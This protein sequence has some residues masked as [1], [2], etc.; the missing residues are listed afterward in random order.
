M[1]CLNW[2]IDTLQRGPLRWRWLNAAVNVTMTVFTAI[3]ARLIAAASRSDFD[4]LASFQISE[5]TINYQGGVVRRGLLGE[6]IFQLCALTGWSPKGVILILCLAS[7]AFVVAYLVR[8]FVKHDLCWWILPTSYMLLPS[9]ICLIRKDFLVIALFITALHLYNRPRWRPPLRLLWLS[10]LSTAI[11]LIYEGIAFVI[12][13]VVALLTLCDR[14]Y[15]AS[16]P[17]RL[18]AL[19][20]PV[21]AMA[22]VSICHGDDSTAR[23][24]HSSWMPWAGEIIEPDRLS[25]SLFAIGWTLDQS[26]TINGSIL[27]AQWTRPIIYTVI[28]RLAMWGLILYIGNRYIATM[29]ANGTYRL[30]HD[31]AAAGRKF[32]SLLMAIFICM[33][34]LWLGLSCDYG[35]LSMHL[36]TITFATCWSIQQ[37][38]IPRW[39]SNITTSLNRSVDRLITPRPIL[40]TA[41]LL[42]TGISAW[43]FFATFL[44][45]YSVLGTIIDYF[46]TGFPQ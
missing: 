24:I 5:F 31:I 26:L 45:H 21:A 27:L 34:P 28:Y 37:D 41:L 18:I 42:L 12:L 6:I 33:A 16:W 46:L 39:W 13:P 19:L 14:S 20:I 9:C 32:S 25:L 1:H 10:L 23:A 7:F 22:A 44:W 17:L 4:N 30:H 40:T 11:I 2:I 43:E 3:V 15:R 38:F 8:Q 36:F 35:R 29:T